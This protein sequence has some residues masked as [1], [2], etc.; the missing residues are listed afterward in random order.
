MQRDEHLPDDQAEVVV[1]DDVVEWLAT[2]VTAAEREQVFDDIVSLFTRPWGK[3]PLSNRSR[4]DRLAGLNTV[5]TID[6]THRVVY[7]AGV[8]PQ[9]VGLI[10]VLAI[11]PRRDNAVYDAVNAMLATGRL[12][13][14]AEQIW[15]LL[16]IYED[17][18]RRFGLELWDYAP[19][20]A[21][22][23]LVRSAVAAGVLPESVARLLSADEIMTALSHAWDP[24]TGRP[25]PAGAVAAAVRRVSGSSD[26]DRLLADRGDPRCG[27]P[28]PR[29]KA[30]CIRRAGHPG[31]HRATP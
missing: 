31:A 6:G 29:A 8:S 23:S 2:N 13:D 21:P 18:A 7:R 5:T 12:D 19:P 10:E 17:T 27:A 14:V 15:G 22:E 30:P 1:S 11:G 4:T 25:D 24:A 16:A 20:P 26:P 9:G 3:H 28:M